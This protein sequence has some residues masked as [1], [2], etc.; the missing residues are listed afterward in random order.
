MS[1]ITSAQSLVSTSSWMESCRSALCLSD[2]QFSLTHFPLMTHWKSCCY[3]YDTCRL[4]VCPSL[5]GSP[6]NYGKCVVAVENDNALR[7]GIIVIHKTYSLFKRR[8]GNLKRSLK[9]IRWI[10]YFVI[11]LTII[12]FTSLNNHRNYIILPM[13]K[14]WRMKI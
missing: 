2:W 12:E 9:R 10:S 3:L 4:R 8:L 14:G 6:I 1:D 7:V 13:A 11:S 5:I